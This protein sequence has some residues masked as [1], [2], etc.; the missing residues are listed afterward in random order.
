[1]AL[2]DA[3]GTL[4]NPLVGELLLYISRI[5]Q[6]AVCGF[7]FVERS[8][9]PRCPDVGMRLEGL[10]KAGLLDGSAI[11]SEHD[12]HLTAHGKEALAMYRMSQP[13]NKLLDK[14]TATVRTHKNRPLSYLDRKARKLYWRKKK[15]QL[16]GAVALKINPVDEAYECTAYWELAAHGMSGHG[17]NKGEILLVDSMTTQFKELIKFFDDLPTCYNAVL[18]AGCC[19]YL[20]VALGK[21]NGVM[22]VSRDR[23]AFIFRNM[24]LL[25]EA[26]DKAR[27]AALNMDLFSL[28]LGYLEDQFDLVQDYLEEANILPRLDGQ[29]IEL[30]RFS[31]SK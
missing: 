12:F 18:S 9:L 8:R 21:T 3:L 17:R 13:L 1:M 15:G 5:E 20:L 25:L 16:K 24:H 22:T 26:L 10:A 4:K 6:T 23:R 14:V 31:L 11:T 19:G 27:H 30:E 29:P 2:V 7:R 28:D